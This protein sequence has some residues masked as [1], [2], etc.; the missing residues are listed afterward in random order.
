MI[1]NFLPPTEESI[2]DLLV[3]MREFYAIDQYPFNLQKAS[4]NIARLSSEPHLGEIWLV[5]AENTI[6]GYTILTFVFSFEHA[7]IVAFLDELFLQERYRKLGLGSKILTFLTDR[8]AELGIVRMH[9]EL[10]KHNVPAK[11]LYGKQ[12]FADTG[13]WLYAKNIDQ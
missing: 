3:L 9:L 11:E 1:L 6:V 7:G 10:E 8:A 5:R 12:G 4:S 2:P 13:R